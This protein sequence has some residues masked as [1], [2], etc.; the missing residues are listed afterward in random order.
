M[1]ADELVIVAVIVALAI[2]GIAMLV[3]MAI[4]LP[5]ILRRLWCRNPDDEE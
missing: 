3:L 1:T 4:W 5:A 2:T